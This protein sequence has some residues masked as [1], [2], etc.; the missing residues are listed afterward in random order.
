M[1]KIYGLFGSMTGKTADVVMV[2]RNGVQ[3]VR[4]YQP[5]VANPSTPAQVAARARL[6]LMSQLSTVMAPAIAIPRQGSVSARN[7]FTKLNYGASSYE[8][9]EASINMESVQL[10]KSVVG[11][12]QVIASR[13]Q[14]GIRAYLPAV[15]GY[16]SLSR[17][18]YVAIAKQA[19][20]TL[21]YASSQVITTPGTGNFEAQFPNIAE[22][23]VIYAYGVRDNTDAA[24]A[25]FGNLEAITAEQ[26]AK[27][28]VTRQVLESDITVT[29]TNAATVAAAA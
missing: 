28:I 19:D 4:K 18:V 25:I 29:E 1:A 12:P 14:E 15:A 11:L 10:T 6:K 13:I 17:V 23:V 7:L 26:V 5:S 27:L 24:K 9:N 20:G 2:V 21:R 8:N 3:I 22:E 16:Q